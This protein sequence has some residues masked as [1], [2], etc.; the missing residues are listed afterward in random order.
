MQCISFQ[1]STH[2]VDP[3]SRKITN[4]NN[5]NNNPTVNAPPGNIP[6]DS[7]TPDSGC[8]LN[9]KKNSLQSNRVDFVLDPN[10]PPPMSFS[11]AE[12]LDSD[13]TLVSS[14]YS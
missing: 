4:S 1:I 7:S 9:N 8:H 2:L 12:S 6:S 5:V 11:P 13:M 3:S 10:P 14:R